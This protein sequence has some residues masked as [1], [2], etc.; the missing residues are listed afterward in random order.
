M[1]RPVRLSVAGL[2][3]VTLTAGCS[4]VS[5]V[6]AT[7]ACELMAGVLAATPTSYDDFNEVRLELSRD[8]F[9]ASMAV[10]KSLPNPNSR[11]A[12]VRKVSRACPDTHEQYWDRWRHLLREREPAQEAQAPPKANPAP[13]PAPSPSR[14]P[15]FDTQEV[16]RS[17]FGDRWPLTVDEGV[18]VCSR[19]GSRVI[20]TFLVTGSTRE[21][22]LNA[23]AERQGFPPINPIWADDPRYASSGAGI[24]IAITPLRSRALELC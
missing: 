9:A 24:K 12:T 4:E 23:S 18:L 20:V 11:Q 15:R 3:L 14:K 17:D 5:S 10:F 6:Q 2:A 22:A 8:N 16:S 13:S 19:E 1:R 7:E 21:Y